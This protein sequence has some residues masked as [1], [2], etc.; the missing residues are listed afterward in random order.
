MKFAKGHRKFG[1][2]KPGSSNKATRDVRE[3]AQKF[4]DDEDYR[5]S[6]R[7]R[8]LRGAAPHMEVLIWHYRFGKPPDKVEMT[9]ED[10][11]LLGVR[12]VF[13]GR[14]KPEGDATS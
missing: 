5:E 3:F 12:I 9:G 8:V 14:Y 6:L 4:I 11:Q 10:G 7:R 1:G 13:G 2:R